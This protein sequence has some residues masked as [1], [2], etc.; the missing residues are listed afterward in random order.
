M[1][2]SILLIS[3]IHGN[4]PAL[5]AIAEHSPPSCFD[6]IINCG[7]SLVYAPFPNETLH[8]L[9]SHK[10]ISILGN[11]DRKVKRLLKKK[12]MHKPRDPEKRV[13]YE[14][15]AKSLTSS[16]CRYLFSLP[17]QQVLQ[18]A[19]E[20]SR[21][22]GIFHGSPDDPDEFL[23][24]DT[25]NGRFEQL[26][27]KGDHHIVVTGHSHSPYHRCHDGVHFINP[28][29]AGRMFDGDVRASFAILTIAESITVTHHRVYYDL[30]RTCKELDRQHLPQIYVQ[31]FQL[32]RKL[33]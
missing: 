11:T 19:D 32:A 3:D 6:H 27:A 13:M 8:W 17:K 9:S 1:T 15:T 23:F 12:S 2:I 5:E 18:L 31:M 21:N 20:Q 25:P 14:S 26:A 7:D 22:I 28:G 4:Y 29:S 24:A 16:A 33:N 10:V 30:E